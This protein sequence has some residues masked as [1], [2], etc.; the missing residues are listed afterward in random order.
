MIIVTTT[1]Y[2]QNTK[3][4]EARYNE[5]IKLFSACKD[6]GYQVITVD[7]ESEAEFRETA[8]SFGV[9][10]KNQQKAGMGNARRQA[11]KE[12]KELT[13]SS[14]VVWLEPEKSGMIP[15]LHLLSEM[16]EQSEIEMVL[17][18]RTSLD[19]YPREQKLEYQFG[20]I[21][22]EYLFGQ[23]IDLFF[24]PVALRG[25]ALEKFL[26]YD[27]K[28]GDLWDSVHIPRL[29]VMKNPRIWRQLMIPY[30][31]PRE[32]T[33][34]EL[35]DLSLFLRRTSQAYSLSIGYID[36]AI[37]Q[38]IIQNPSSVLKEYLDELKKRLIHD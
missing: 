28:Y 6:R 2:D 32:Q 29:I 14:F 35:G 19:S 17:F 3:S 20:Q 24:G 13:N 12:A 10:I 38:G 5:A 27:G 7:K 15:H 18:H 1:K 8:Q 36:E 33:S 11:L 23:C 21:L 16:E 37:N 34:A 31:N 25:S 9:I 26:E 4:R 22:G 30:S